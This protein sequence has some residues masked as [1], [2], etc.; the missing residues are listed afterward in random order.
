MK[1]ESKDK[2]FSLSFAINNYK[3]SATSSRSSTLSFV[4]YRMG[5]GDQN[6]LVRLL[7]ICVMLIMYEGWCPHIAD[8]K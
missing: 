1:S 6:Y 5:R 8:N 3:A 4:T 7:K 2:I